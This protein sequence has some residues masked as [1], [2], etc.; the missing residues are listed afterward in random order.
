MDSKQ[1]PKE[2]FLIYVDPELLKDF[3]KACIDENISYTD[4]VTELFKWYLKARK[5]SF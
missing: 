1:E 5:K 3:K 2:Q 4:K